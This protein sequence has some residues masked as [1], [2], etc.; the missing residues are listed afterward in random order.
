[1]CRFN[2]S[3]LFKYVAI[4]AFFI[5]LLLFNKGQAADATWRLMHNNHDALIIGEIVNIEKNIGTIK[6]TKNI[7]SSKD[8]NVSHPRKQIILKEAKVILPD[9]Y[10]GFYDIENSKPLIK[11]AVGDYVLLS[12][13]KEGNVF[14]VAWGAFKV[15]SLDYRKLS[16]MLP[17]TVNDG[18]KREVSAI[19][20]F[21]NSNGKIVDN[22]FDVVESVTGIVYHPYDIEII[23]KDNNSTVSNLTY[24]EVKIGDSDGSTKEIVTEDK[25]NEKLVT[26]KEEYL[27]NIIISLILLVAVFITIVIKRIKNKNG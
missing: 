9:G 7:I 1:M 22:A 19:K 12:I 25:N 8:L 10:F 14:R 4:L 5:F 23:N 18:T 17:S 26:T 24:S 21:V 15:D 2:M 16:I 6:V 11:P 13:S 27:E 20:V 3:R